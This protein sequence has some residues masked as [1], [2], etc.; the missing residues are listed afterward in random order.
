MP[1]KPAPEAARFAQAAVQATQ[2]A[3]VLHDLDALLDRDPL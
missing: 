1:R 3:P 2:T